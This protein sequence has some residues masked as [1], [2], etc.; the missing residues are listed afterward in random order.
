[1]KTL[2]ACLAILGCVRADEVSIPN[3]FIVSYNADPFSFSIL[4]SDSGAVLLSTAPQSLGESDWN[5]VYIPL[6]L[7]YLVRFGYTDMSVTPDHI[8]NTTQTP[9]GVTF[10]IGSDN[11]N[12][13]LNLHISSVKKYVVSVDLSASC[14]HR[15]NRL[16]LSTHSPDDELFF[17]FGERF[18]AL[19]QR[20]QRLQNWIEDGGWG[21]GTD[22]RIPAGRTSS[23]YALPYFVSSRGYAMFVNSTFRTTFDM[24][25]AHPNVVR[26][27]TEDSKAQLVYFFGDTPAHSVALYGEAV[28][29]PRT[30]PLFSWGPWNQLND[31]LRDAHGDMVAA[32]KAFVARDIPLAIGHDALHFFPKGNQRDVLPAVIAR[33]AALRA[34]GVKTLAYFNPYVATVYQPI[35]DELAAMGGFVKNASG[36]PYLFSYKGAGPNLFGVA[37]I[38][39]TNPQAVARYQKE[40]ASAIS[41]GYSGFMY[42]YAEYFPADGSTSD[43]RGGLE[44]HNLY[45]VLYQKASPPPP[46]AR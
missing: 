30:P 5:G 6:Y 20:G 23:Y 38:D 13:S 42:D 24:A 37:Q 26:V 46:S 18:E 22:L 31:E 11:P 7:G 9:D 15:V 44:M 45:P 21:F 35:F 8:S 14:M 43:G 34:M 4:S 27:E 25:R 29:T 32:A 12:C 19:N 40:I 28:G 10:I 36:Q 39:F 2:L 1:M 17:G 3:S 16:S 41:A 33:N